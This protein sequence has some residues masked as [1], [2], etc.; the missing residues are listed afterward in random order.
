M[1]NISMLGQ[2]QEV[3]GQRAEDPQERN[4]GSAQEASCSSVHGKSTQDSHRDIMT[5]KGSHMLCFSLKGWQ[6][7]KTTYSYIPSKR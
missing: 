4:G 1:C 7:V 3:Q 2:G 6:G 5:L